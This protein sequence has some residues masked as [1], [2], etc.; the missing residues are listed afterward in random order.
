MKKFNK[1]C[2][3]RFRSSLVSYF[4]LAYAQV[5]VINTQ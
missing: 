3:E 4:T 1:K 5:A 2:N